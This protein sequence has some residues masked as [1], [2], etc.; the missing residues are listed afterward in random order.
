MNTISG[1][2]GTASRK[3]FSAAL[4]WVSAIVARTRIRSGVRV[5]GVDG[6]AVLVAFVTL[7]LRDETG[8]EPS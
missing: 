5:P 7:G 2:A 4:K 1:S 8:G 6:R 3:L